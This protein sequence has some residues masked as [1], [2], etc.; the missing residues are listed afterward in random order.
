MWPRL[1]SSKLVSRWLALTL[2]ASIVAAVDGGWLWRWASLAPS[3]VWRG[4]IWRIATWPF[5]ELGPLQLV[6]TCVA[7]YKFGGDLAVRWG[8]RRLRRFMIEVLGSAAVA[9]C[10]L[11]AVTGAGYVQRAGGWAVGD[12]LAIAWAR[13]FPEQPLVLYGLLVLRGRQIVRILL[14]VTIV[15]AVFIGPV[16]MAPELA[17]CAA[18]ALYPR[19]W[20]ARR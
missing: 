16:Y 20:L 8:E 14:A 9:T 17:A 19:G 15:Y 6:L 10:V 4:E 18:A 13:Q 3:R 5:L 1:G 7:I 2:A 11:A 12:V